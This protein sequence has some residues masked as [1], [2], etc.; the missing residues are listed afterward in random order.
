M[1]PGYPPPGP[2]YQ[3]PPVT[4]RI[5]EDLPFVVR[6]SIRKRATLWGALVGGIGLFFGCGA[7]VVASSAPDGGGFGWLVGL[8]AFLVIVVLFGGVF[9]LQLWIIATGGPVLAASPAGMWIKTRPTRGQAIWLPWE[10]IAQISRRRWSF[11]KMVVVKPR[12]PRATSHLGAYTAVDSSMLQ[13]FY[14]SG[15]TATVNFADKPEAEIMSALS[16]LAAGRT[17]F[18]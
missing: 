10:G 11:E 13:L 8:I 6:N 18:V 15:F 4:R 5:P 14:G 7:G 2:L 12:D 16:Q 17:P 1:V 9:S 3:P